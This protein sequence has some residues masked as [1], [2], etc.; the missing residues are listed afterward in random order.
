ME[1]WQEDG[2]TFLG[3]GKYIVDILKIFQME[4]YKP[5][6]TPMIANLKK[7]IT[8]YSNL[9]DHTLYKKMIGFFMYMVN[10]DRYMF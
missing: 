5:M 4:D 10:Q 6:A 3:K 2:H 7:V 9:V 1:V 8:S